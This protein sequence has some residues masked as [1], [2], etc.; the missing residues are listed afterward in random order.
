M[1]RRLNEEVVS[2]P[3]AVPDWTGELLRELSANAEI[4]ARIAE[5]QRRIVEMEREIH[6]EES[7]KREAF[8]KWTGLVRLDGPGFQAAVQ[9]ALQLLGFE[10]SASA[11]G[12]PDEFVARHGAQAFLVHGAGS[13]G[14]I[15]VEHGRRLLH[16]I[17]DAEDLEGTRGL[18][19]GNG[20]RGDPP[21]NRPPQIFAPELER[22]ALKHHFSLL[23]TRQL[24]RVVA[25]RLQGKAVSME[26]IL[27]ELS[28]DGPVTFHLP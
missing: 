24:F 23:D 8:E 17:A 5:L 13:V 2:G 4:D 27:R 21:W 9:E 7:R 20:F 1:N 22:M 25:R 6:A 28:V 11:S 14:A 3:A 15:L 26:M 16:W 12:S 10:I 18:V 19:V